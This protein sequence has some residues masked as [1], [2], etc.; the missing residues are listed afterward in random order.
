MHIFPA[1]DLKNNKCVRLVKG[2]DNTSKVFNDN[3]VDQAI[4]FEKQGCKRLHL[5]DL[6]AAFGR[7]GINIKTIE[8]IRQAI[9]IPIQL[10]GGIRS[11]KQAKFFFEMNIDY[12]IIGSFAINNSEDAIDLSEKYKNKIYVSLDVLEESIMIRGWE[13]KTNLKTNDVFFKYNNSKIKGYILT[14]VQNDGMLTGLNIDL[15]SKN[16]KLSS[17]KIIVGGGLAS[18]RDLKKLTKINSSNLEG[19]IAG[20]SYYV[21]RI[22][23]K[24]AQKVLASHA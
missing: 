21:G 3:P 5:V 12:L 24:K 2:Q 13:E 18:Y 8:K 16:L 19:I 22:N 7:S 15:I 14:D 6:D 9:S 23:L 20:K 10:G 17:K 1:I 11:K 4:Y